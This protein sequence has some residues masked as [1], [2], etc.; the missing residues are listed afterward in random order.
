MLR[1]VFISIATFVFLFLCTTLVYSYDKEL[2]ERSVQ[3]STIHSSE[4]SATLQADLTECPVFSV[5]EEDVA[6]FFST[7]TLWALPANTQAVSIAIE[8]SAYRLLSSDEL[9]TLEDIPTETLPSLVTVSP[10]MRMRGVALTSI[11]INPVQPSPSGDGF[12]FYEDAR[13]SLSY[14]QAG[15]EPVRPLPR[16]FYEVMRPLIRNLDEIIGDP[17]RN[18]EPYL[19]ITAPGYLGAALE[20]FVFWKQQRGHTVDLVTT[21]TTGTTNQSIRS[22]LQQRYDT[23]ETPPVFVVLI[24]DVDGVNAMPGWNIQGYH[25]AS[26]ISDHLYTLLDGDDY[27][28]DVL[29]GRLSVDSQFELQTVVNKCV[30]Y[31]REPYLPEGDWRSR[32]AI[33]GV[34]STP[35][36]FTSYNSAWPTLLWVAQEF[37]DAGY[38]DID[39]IMYPGGQASQINSSI[40]G[41]L[42]FL[43]YR[44]FGSPSDWAYPIYTI[45]NIS[46]TTNGEMLPVITSI[47]CGGGAFE[48]PTDPCFGEAWLRRGTPTSPAGAVGFIGPSELDTKTRWNNTNTA[49]IYTGIL[50]EGVNTLSGAMLRG[51]MELIHQFPN[52]VNT[53]EANANTSVP[54][55]FR[56]YNLLGDPGLNFYVGP[57]RPIGYEITSELVLGMPSASISVWNS[58]GALADV[59]GT[60]SVNGAVYSRSISDESGSLV[61]AL[62]QTNADTIEIVLTKPRF[63]PQIINETLVDEDGTVAASN[64]I[65]YDDGSHESIGNGDGQ[66][67]TGERLAF[68]FDITNYGN[69]TIEGNQMLNVSSDDERV[70]ITDGSHLL[71]EI[72]P[73]ETVEGLDFFVEVRFGAGGP[74]PLV[75]DWWFQGIMST[76]QTSHEILT[77]RLTVSGVATDGGIGSPEPGMTQSISLIVHNFGEATMPISIATLTSFDDR[78]QILDSIA[79]YDPIQPGMTSSG[80]GTNNFQI[81]VDEMYPGERIPVQVK[82]ER[83]I[84]G[85]NYLIVDYDL[86]I[87]NLT[88]SDPTA[89]DGYGYRAYDSWDAGYPEAPQYSWF[90]IDPHYGGPGTILQVSDIAAG[91]DATVTVDLPFSFSFYGNSYSQ[92]S[93]CTNGFAAFGDTDESYFRNYAIPAIASPERMLCPFWDDL[94][95]GN[96]RIC[97]YYHEASGRFIVQ[98]SRMENAYGNG[99]IETFQLMLYDTD[100]WPTRTGDG[101][102]LFQYHTINNVDAWDNYATIGIQ[103]RTAGFALPLS[104]ASFPVPGFRSPRARSAV[105]ITTGRD[106]SGPY[107]VFG[108]NMIDDDNEGAS[109]GNGNGT[110]QNGETIELAVQLS[111]IGTVDMPASAGVLLEMDPQVELITSELAF[112]AIP[113][114]ASV[115]SNPVVVELSPAIPNGK[116]VN[117]TLSLGEGALP[118]VVLP[119]LT[120][121]GPVLNSVA[122][123]VDDDETDASSGN[124]NHEFNPLE[125]I[126][127]FPTIQNSGEN[128]AS[129]V[130]ATLIRNNTN[131]S[132]LDNSVPIGIV[133]ADT[134]FEAAEPFLVQVP[135]GIGNSRP[136]EFTLTLTDGYGVSWESDFSFVV[137]E[138]ILEFENFR[139]ADPV[140][141]GNDDGRISPGE[142]VEVYLKLR[143]RGIGSATNVEIE[144]LSIS[145]GATVD[146]MFYP[147][148]SVSGNSFREM[149]DPFYLTIAETVTEPSLLVMNVRISCSERNP[150]TEQIPVIIGHAGFIDDFE[151]SYNRW[152]TYGTPGLWNRQSEQYVSESTAYYCGNLNSHSYPSYSDAYLRSPYFEFPG[153]GTLVVSTRYDIPDYADRARIDLQTGVTTYQMLA[154]INGTDLEWHE[155]RLPLDGLPPT[156]RARIRFWFSSNSRDEGGGWYIDDVQLLDASSPVSDF[157]PE[158]VPEEVTLAQNFPNPFNDRTS[159]TYTIPKSMHVRLSL[160]NIEGRKVI[161]LVNERQD[162]G[163]YRAAWQPISLA[164]GLYFARL[165][166]GNRMITR[167]L[168]YLR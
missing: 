38:T 44:G 63:H 24:G 2:H 49:G 122:L 10:V 70:R 120:V 125:T 154:E 123:R 89:P 121:T 3:F 143:N 25:T 8:S 47:V 86:M 131:I 82:F 151:N 43:T 118:C 126:E 50:H 28:P 124:G 139:F 56:C 163:K 61:L 93:V 113:A 48:S 37:L 33:V 18:P 168:V 55:Y 66:F 157:G 79:T 91:Y 102:I 60:V 164:S 22:Y 97:A 34:R 98:W 74:Y 14:D 145:D 117:F 112:P 16:A 138:T 51:K 129:N 31:E 165:E 71:P 162:A 142:T 166:A 109:S 152:S 114:G 100:C 95:S 57:A 12:V 46:G 137:A 81:S 27:L 26:I 92:L 156:N 108:G 140:P 99:T 94:I 116:F 75:L 85:G 53:D 158:A 101:D 88:D 23:D 68:V 72:L 76:W 30:K 96:G 153:H 133:E 144:V 128:L 11:A 39:S 106:T 62:P 136:I 90:E 135:W 6:Q 105:L 17:D 64:I 52:N 20:Q 36:T 84:V 103:D 148:G 59:R 159:F 35:H 149:D 107:V 83:N 7:G 21:E 110:A 78:I 40:N 141:G 5:D 13:F 111:N 15:S 134:T 115:S 29:I 19:I 119:T 167:K 130:T 77:P 9:E 150:F 147:F 41:G 146:P 80:S 161:D 132:I 127:L 65:I 54:F 104:Y 58:E 155:L 1:N 32:M 4:F 67:S 160:Y 45:G 73:G 42:S 69:S 87:G